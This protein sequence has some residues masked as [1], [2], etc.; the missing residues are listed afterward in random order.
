[1]DTLV[2]NICWILLNYDR[3]S[4]TLMFLIYSPCTQGL[5]HCVL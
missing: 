3:N 5:C 4:F 1:M 2:L